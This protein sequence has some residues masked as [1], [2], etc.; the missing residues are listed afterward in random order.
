MH[1]TQSPT[2]PSGQTL[3]YYVCPTRLN[4]PEDQARWPGHLRASFREEVLTEKLSEFLDTYA[5][6]YDRVAR[7]A[8]LIPASQAQQDDLDHARAETLERKRKQAD[9]AITGIAAEIGQLA[10]K[11]DPVSTA[12]RDRLT[13]AVQPA[14]RREGRA[15]SRA[16]GHR[17]RRA[18]ARQRPVPAR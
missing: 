4:K 18:A 9:A 5:L 7:L 11:T 15:R 10:G 2:T 12:I 6:G 13:A 8:E 3:V 16:A 17:G 1:G 14:L